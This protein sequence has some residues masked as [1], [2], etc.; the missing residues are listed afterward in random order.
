MDAYC[1]FL[2]DPQDERVHGLRVVDG[3]QPLKLRRGA[4]PG[5]EPRQQRLGRELQGLRRLN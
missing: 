2:F 4:L 5:L 1:F 3:R